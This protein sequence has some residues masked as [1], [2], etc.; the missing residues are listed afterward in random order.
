[1]FS[2]VPYGIL[3]DHKDLL[4]ALDIEAQILSDEEDE[5]IEQVVTGDGNIDAA[6]L[7]DEPTDDDKSWEV[8]DEADR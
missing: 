8:D 6:A 7:E 4:N 1:M 2:Q 5:L 3:S